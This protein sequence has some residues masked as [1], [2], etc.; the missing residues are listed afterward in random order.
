MVTSFVFFPIHDDCE[1]RFTQENF[2][3]HRTAFEIEEEK[4]SLGFLRLLFTKKFQFLVN[5]VHR[6]ECLTKNNSVNDTILPRKPIIFINKYFSGIRL[7]DQFRSY[8]KTEHCEIP[9]ED[10]I[11]VNSEIKDEQYT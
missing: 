4:F 2:V 5:T 8:A 6:F 3:M 9:T 10:Q 7:L 11:L 1:A